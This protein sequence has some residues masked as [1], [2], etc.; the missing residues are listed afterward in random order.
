MADVDVDIE[1]R[2]TK[3]LRVNRVHAWVEPPRRRAR[4]ES[5]MTGTKD[6]SRMDWIER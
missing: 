4:G 6:D 5:S 3:H 1:H 2:R